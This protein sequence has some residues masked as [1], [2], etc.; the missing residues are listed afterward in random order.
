MN[1]VA[2]KLTFSSVLH[3]L[4]LTINCRCSCPVHGGDNKS[5]FSVDEYGNWVCWSR[6]CHENFPQGIIG[7][8]MGIK[9]INYQQ[10]QKYIQDTARI[11]S[12]PKPHYTRSD[13]KEII[14]LDDFAHKEY[15]RYFLT[16]GGFDKE[17]L[18]K[19]RVFDC[20]KSGPLQNR[21]VVPVYNITNKLVGYT[22]RTMTNSS[23]KWYHY[24]KSFKTSHHL[25]GL[26]I[27]HEYIKE[28]QTV[29]LVEG[30][31]DC[32]RLYET[33]FY[34]FA[35]LF[36]TNISQYQ[37]EILSSLGVKK[38]V[39]LTDPDLAASFSSLKENGLADQLHR[40]NYEVYSLRHL[41][42]NDVGDTNANTVYEKLYSE[43]RKIYYENNYN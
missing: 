6:R 30:P 22:A 3:D 39:I 28:T 4:G 15:P 20:Y 2:T 18:K 13:F 17:T 27:S 29:I 32:W 9:G 24:P 12:I 16:N 5:S 10:A 1:Q 21:S 26:N 42:E 31:K 23:I 25:C 40:K 11:K 37:L 35:G 38:V 36:G 33:G 14:L 8:V 41:F 43:M 7:L 34:N 19:F